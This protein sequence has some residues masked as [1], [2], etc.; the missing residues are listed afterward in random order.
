MRVCHCSVMHLDKLL[1]EE[2]LQLGIRVLAD[3]M[4]HPVVL[5]T[6]EWERKESRILCVNKYILSACACQALK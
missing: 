6:L 5:C 1:E 4:L 3:L 2:S